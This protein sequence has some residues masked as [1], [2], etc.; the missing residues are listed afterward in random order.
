MKRIKKGVT[1]IAALEMGVNLGALALRKPAEPKGH[2]AI[3]S[4]VQALGFGHRMI[5]AN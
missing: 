5:S 3:R 1:C 2:Q 4:R